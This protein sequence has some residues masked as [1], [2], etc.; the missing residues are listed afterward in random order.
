[1]KTSF[2]TC[3]GPESREETQR[4]TKPFLAELLLGLFT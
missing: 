4:K 3:R 2:A 1:M